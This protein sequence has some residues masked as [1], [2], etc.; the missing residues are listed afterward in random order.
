MGRLEATR[1]KH[2]RCFLASGCRMSDKLVEMA[3]DSARG[4]LFLLTGNVLSLLILA[5][6]R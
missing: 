3:E 6:A 2:F 1:L 4:G 5:S